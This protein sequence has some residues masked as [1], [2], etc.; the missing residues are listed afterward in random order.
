MNVASK[1]QHRYFSQQY[2]AGC[3][4]LKSCDVFVLNSA[5]RH[6]QRVKKFF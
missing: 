2:C 3:E 1:C 4:L 5:F 6:L